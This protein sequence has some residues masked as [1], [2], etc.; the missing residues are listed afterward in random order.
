MWNHLIP[1]D[2]KCPCLAHLIQGTPLI[3]LDLKH[4]CLILVKFHL[5]VQHG[6]PCPKF[7]MLDNQYYAPL[8]KT[9]YFAIQDH[10]LLNSQLHNVKV[11]ALVN[12]GEYKDKTMFVYGALRDGQA[13]IHGKFGKTISILQPEWISLVPPDVTCHEALLII[14]KGQH[15]G[16][17]AHRIHHGLSGTQKTALV[18]IIN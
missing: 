14:I 10:I 8:I 16:R 2:L 3:L 18:A 4:L 9:D 17:F 13:H 1:P 12:G 15:F 5:L 11:K 6:T 7:L